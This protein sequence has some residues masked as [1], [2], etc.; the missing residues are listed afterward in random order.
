MRP[1]RITPEA[2]ATPHHAPPVVRAPRGP[3]SKSTVSQV[4]PV[5]GRASRR[6]LSGAMQAARAEASGYSLSTQACSRIPRRA[7]LAR[8]RHARS[9]VRP[10]QVKSSQVKSS[11]VC[12][13]QIT[14]GPPWDAPGP[15]LARTPRRGTHPGPPENGTP[16]G[17][18]AR[19]R[20]AVSRWSVSVRRVRAAA[21][22]HT[23]AARVKSSQVESPPKPHPPNP[24]TSTD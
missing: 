2:V 13:L 24:Q 16:Q 3:S 14:R 10:S 12:H 19:L 8:P 21:G 17:T 4:N 23:C 5:A 22:A 1:Y 7:P 6:S 18:H 15:C 20:P 9:R 11:Q